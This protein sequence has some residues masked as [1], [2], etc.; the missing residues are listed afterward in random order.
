MVFSSILFMFI[1]LPV[2]L[3]LYYVSP[4]RWRNPIL[5]LANLVFYGWG[6]P[7][8]IVLMLFSIT[9][10]YINGMLIGRWKLEKQKRA[11][12]VLAI[13]VVI[14][15]ALLG[16]FKY[17][18]LIAETL[19]LLPFINIKPLGIALP[20]G[21]SFYTFQTMS[22]PIDVYRGDADVQRNYISFGTFVALF[23]Q[24]IAGPIVRYKDVADQ[25]SFRASSID[26]FSSGVE[27]FMVGVAKKVLI[28]NNLG[29]LWD[30]YAA[31][32]QGELTFLG[33]WLGIIA[34]S[35]QIYFD[36][37]GYSDMAIGLGR[38]LGFEFMENFNYPYISKSIT[39]FWR[40]WHISLSTWFREYLYIPLGGNRCSKPRWVFNLLIVWAA[41]GIWHGASWNFVL[42]GLY[43]F[44]FL[45]LEKLV[46]G[47]A[48]ARLPAAVQHVYT[49]FLVLVSWAIFAIE[50]FGQLV[51]YLKV[52]F[53]LGG[54]PLADGAFGYYLRS[55]LP[56]LVIAG[57]GS[58]PLLSKLWHKLP[59]KAAAVAMPVLLLAGLMVCTGYVVDATYNPFL[60]FRF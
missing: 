35:L 12:A 38:M 23:P 21:I 50:D 44:V 20:I 60:Y 58:T 13:N 33:S 43:F 1:Y 16:F 40:R 59:R 5:F 6:E 45:M 26:Q 54:V 47:R 39:E 51:P 52:M 22:Y 57:V 37:S 15:L 27:R 3:F 17:Y 46:W 25:L 14:N 29:K 34:F 32:P 36:F 41:T 53:G 4:V 18:D 9:I 2:V 7:V 42:W 28:A 19:S 8:F 24:L 55:Y 30:Y 49:L 11:K 48:L 10:N 31:I 56:L